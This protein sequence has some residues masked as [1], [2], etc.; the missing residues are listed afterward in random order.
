MTTDTAEA[1]VIV[2]VRLPR[3]L[4]KEI[5]R[6]CVDVALNR[7]ELVEQFLREGVK[8]YEGRPLDVAPGAFR[9]ARG[10][11]SRADR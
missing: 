5:D 6:L 10:I 7:A 9:R 2:Q 4:V 1:S 11:L 8:R 3:S